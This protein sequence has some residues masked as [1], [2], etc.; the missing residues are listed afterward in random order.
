MK[1]H[2]ILDFLFMLNIF[3]LNFFLNPIYFPSSCRKKEQNRQNR[4]QTSQIF[5][6][7][8]VEW[9]AQ[10]LRLTTCECSYF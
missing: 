1:K 4:S 9:A 3:S 5:L 7:T 2:K 10:A 6:E 8:T